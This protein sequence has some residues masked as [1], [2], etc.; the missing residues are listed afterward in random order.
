MTA[1]AAI[2]EGLLSPYEYIQ[3][4]PVATYGLDKQ[5]FKNWNPYTNQPMTLTTALAQ[6]CDTYFYDVGNRYF[7]AR[8]AERPYWTKMQGWA[9]R[10]GFGQ[11]TG[12]DVGGE[13]AGL[14]PT[15]AW[16]KQ[17]SPTA[18]DRAWNPGDLIQ[19]AIGQK[20]INVTPLQM[21]RFYAALANGGKLVTPYI[22]SAVEQP[23]D[24]GSPAR[25]AAHVPAAAAAADRR[26]PG[27]ARVVREG[28]YAGDARRRRHLVGRLRQLP[29]AG[30]GQDRHGRE[31][32]RPA[33]LPDRAPRG[34]GR[35]GAAGGRRR[36]ARTRHAAPIVVCAVIENG[37]H[38][39]TAA[40]P[41]ALKV[42]E[43]WFRRARRRPGEVRRD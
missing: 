32:R 41:A 27:R 23:G 25:A 33:R 7:D 14:M 1:L 22:V 29:G 3:C 37:G 43:Q 9:Q 38:G 2:S 28:L 16:R 12:L 11:T 15:P 31:G 17:R 18:I 42:F 39:G 26:R 19:L 10:F 13:A 5:P 21:A 20:D 34:P 30:R 8:R 36:R 4:T 24:D 40:A 6:S 35:G